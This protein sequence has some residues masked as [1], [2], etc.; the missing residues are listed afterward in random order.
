M[1]SVKTRRLAV[2]VVVACFGV[3]GSAAS[4]HAAGGLAVTPAILEHQAKVG[5]VGSMTLSNTTTES[6]KVTVTVRPWRQELG[7]RVLSDPRATLS[8]YVRASTT[9]FTIGAGAK[10]PLTF[11]MLRRPSSGSLYGNVDIFGK[12]V[13][14]KGRK[15]II[16]QYRLI[17]SL[18]LTP[19][20][21]KLGVKTGAAQVRG[22]HVLL[23]VRNMGN[24][25]DPVAGS[26]KISGP[27]S[28]NG[29][30]PAIPALPGKLVGLDLG[31]TAGRKKGRYTV[32]ATVTQGGRNKTVSTS[33][34]IR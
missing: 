6:L 18:R 19:A 3:L 24:T 12:P 11:K 34:T 2:P 21:K 1:V 20:S 9:S 30:M 14:T 22:G 27:T 33:F 29:T 28:R 17:S 32:S 16:P 4:A 13:N 10:R 7:G 31:A 15:G 26:F 5:T 23:P 8:R 25:I